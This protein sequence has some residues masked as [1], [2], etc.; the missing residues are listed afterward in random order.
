MKLTKLFKKA[1]TNIK[2]ISNYSTK[3]QLDN[4]NKRCRIFPKTIEF[5]DKYKKR[6]NG[7]L[8][9]YEIEKTFDT[10]NES[11]SDKTVQDYNVVPHY[12]DYD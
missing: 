11:L 1:N 3:C 9:D 8:S 5:R 4:I 7:I 12:A 10:V 2:R 6:L